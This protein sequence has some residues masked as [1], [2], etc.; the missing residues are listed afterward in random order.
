MYEIIIFICSIIF[1]NSFQ[2]VYSCKYPLTKRLNN[3]NHLLIC[4]TEIYFLDSNYENIINQLNTSNCESSCVISIA[5]TQFLKEDNS[6]VVIF[7][8]GI[9]YIFSE[10]GLLLSNISIPLNNTGKIYSL[11][12]YGH[13]N[14]NFYYALIFTESTNII[15]DTYEFSSSSNKITFKNSSSYNTLNNFDVEISCQ[16]MN[17]S[18]NNIITCFYG[19]N[20]YFICNNFDPF[21][22][23][24]SIL[25][26]NS[27]S[28]SYTYYK[29]GYSKSEVMTDFRNKAICCI[30]IDHYYICIG[31]DINTNVLTN[32]NYHVESYNYGPYLIFMIKYFPETNEFL[33]GCFGD[34][35]E[36]RNFY[37][38]RYT[39]NFETSS[40]MTIINGIIPNNCS[41]PNNIDFIYSSDKNKYS[42]LTSES[43]NYCSLIT[44]NNININL[45]CT[46]YYNYEHTN[47]LDN[48][49][50]GY[51]LNDSNLKTLDKCHLSCKTCDK[52]ETL[53]STNCKSCFD[54]KYLEFGNC[55][56]QCDKGTF[57]DP[58]DNTIVRCKC[59]TLTKCEYCSLE[60]IE[61]DL[62]ITCN[63]DL[64]YYQ[65]YN[66]S[67]NIIIN[68]DESFIDC[69]K[70]PDYFYLD[71]DTFNYIPCYETCKKCYGKGDKNN[72]NCIECIFNYKFL[73]DSY[74]NETNCYNIC[75]YYYY[76]D[77]ENKY[78]CTKENKC[79]DNYYL[80]RNKSKCVDDCKNDNLY[81]YEYNNECYMDLPLSTLPIS[82]LPISTL[83]ES[84]LSKTT[85]PIS[86]LPI[87]TFTL[88]TLPISTLVISTLLISTSILESDI[89]S[90]N[91]ITSINKDIDMEIC[92]EEYP[93]FNIKTNMCIKDCNIN[94]FLN[95]DCSTDNENDETVE[96]NLD[97]IK[98][99]I[100][101]HLIDDLLDDI[102]KGGED[103]T[104]NEK[105]TKY[106]LSSSSNQNNNEYK[107]ISNIKLGVIQIFNQIINNI[108]FYSVAPV[109]LFIK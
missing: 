71:N 11:I 66:D 12:A 57:L 38:T 105:N 20:Y 108:Y 93:Y 10:D 85:L 32:N 5:F 4:S 9:N 106:Q 28:V 37:Y 70:E 17:Y 95:S 56:S 19:Y 65:I 79:P 39:Q 87:S 102:L 91:L 47:C 49:P 83:P 69:Y 30:I 3:G 67:N 103:K 50:D 92:P 90:N 23:F 109:Y 101:E 15:F 86:A 18:N 7:R 52:K 42:I 44:L 41:S 84:T 74:V 100:S 62:C 46:H 63:K 73:K 88:S 40:G 33:A 75:D 98:D 53:N 51:Y 58:N 43:N 60:S 104:I 16:L 21:N 22:N 82:T 61:L 99:A 27:T 107:D 13:S 26:V 34:F 36:N 24:Q 54:N 89:S 77:E 68:N 64:G 97:K 48:I 76:F 96:N 78:Q 1:K 14:Q 25:N 2:Y 8:N 59:N 94:D 81:K 31:Y 35:R 45:N 29:E 6:Y 72:N 80:I 55:V